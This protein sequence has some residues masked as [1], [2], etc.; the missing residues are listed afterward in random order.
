VLFTIAIAKYELLDIT[1]SLAAEDILSYM[2]D[3]L[4]IFDNKGKII[5]ASDSLFK[6]LGYR[7]NELISNSIDIVFD[8]DKS[9]IEKIIKDTNEKNKVK[10]VETSIYK[11]DGQKIKVSASCSIIKDRSGKNLGY[12]LV[13]RNISEILKLIEDLKQRTNELEQAKVSLVQRNEELEKLNRFMVGRERR[14]D[15]LKQQLQSKS[16][17]ENL[18]TEEK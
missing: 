6:N 1:P 2:L 5:L 17:S 4:I 18:D 8:K 9:A 11:K 10:N 15:D 3:E 14:M 7:K 16:S 12:L 13:M